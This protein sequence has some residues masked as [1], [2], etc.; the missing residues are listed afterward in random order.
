M[1]IDLSALIESMQAA[2][3]I[4]EIAQASSIKLKATTSP[5]EPLL[6]VGVDLLVLLSNILREDFRGIVT[7]NPELIFSERWLDPLGNP[8]QIR[9]FPKRSRILGPDKYSS[10]LCMKFAKYLIYLKKAIQLDFHGLL[11]EPDLWQSRYKIAKEFQNMMFQQLEQKLKLIKKHKRA[12]HHRN[13]RLAR[14]RRRK[15]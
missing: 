1:E 12:V 6:E 9:K 14:K 13:I 15:L 5:L 3:A 4:L 11:W 10:R 2:L 7:P 8:L